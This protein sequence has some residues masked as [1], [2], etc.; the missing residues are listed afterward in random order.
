MNRGQLQSDAKALGRNS[1][2]GQLSAIEERRTNLLNTV[3]Q[4]K[5]R[6]PNGIDLNDDDDDDELVE[7]Q[8]LPLPSSM[9]TA[10]QSPEA[11]AVEKNLRE[12]QAFE[13]L[14]SLRKLLAERVALQRNQQKDQQGQN[15]RTR[16]S[17]IINRVSEEIRRIVKRYQTNYRALEALG[18]LPHPTL[19][20]L[21][22]GD[23]TATNVFNIT[24]RIGRGTDTNVS[25]IWRQV[26]IGEDVQSDSW[27]EEGE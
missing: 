20:E 8:R 25:W 24:E 21:K 9:L 13:L 15:A 18:A 14:Q 26:P 19:Q 27:L 22:D 11:R 7:L 6:A 17:C 3:N 12:A 10:D 5:A 2:E 23:A 16:S 4:W 1:T